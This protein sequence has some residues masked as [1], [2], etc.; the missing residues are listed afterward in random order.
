MFN[1]KEFGAIGNGIVDDRASIQKAIAAAGNAGGDVFF[2]MGTYLVSSAGTAAFCIRLASKV[3]LIGESRAGSILKQAN[4]LGSSVRLVQIE[5]DDCSLNNLTLDGNKAKQSIDEQRHGIF[6]VRANR[7]LVE[8]V[9]SQ[10][11][12]GDG[13]YIGSKVS[14]VTFSNVLATLNGR[15]GIALAG[16]GN[17]SDVNIIN[18]TCI[19]NAAQQ[20]DSEPKTSLDRQGNPIIDTS[21][22]VNNVTISGCLIDPGSSQEYAVTCSGGGPKD[23]DRSHGWTITGNIIKGS[24]L[25]VWCDDVCITGNVID[26]PKSAACVE[27]KRTAK[28][29]IV[30][31]NRL[32]LS[33]TTTPGVAAISVIGNKEGSIFDVPSLVSIANNTIGVSD[34]RCLSI[35]AQGADSVSIMGNQ[36]DGGMIQ[37]RATAFGSAVFRSAIVIGNTIA[38]V[39][40][41]D[42][43]RTGSAIECVGDKQAPAAGRF[44]IVDISHNVIINS[45]LETAA[46]AL[47]QGI[48]FSNDSLFDDAIII[49]GKKLNEDIQ[50]TMIGNHIHGSKAPLT[51]FPKV[52]YLTGGNRGAGAVFGRAQ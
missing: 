9:T 7:L 52:P 28:N 26:N 50:I 32:K 17:I 38:N 11:F 14:Q 36:I 42:I 10:N 12:T 16:N 20:I 15:S 48:F 37:V 8:N 19:S 1:V 27:I 39:K 13:F 18:S 2:P 21:A 49:D 29:I 43:N 41:S 45:P 23:A 46:T 30:T 51:N 24:V 34:P 47:K 25:V 35:I 22:Q 40:L 44:A 6:V 5:S 33:Q 4:N 31:G 3:K